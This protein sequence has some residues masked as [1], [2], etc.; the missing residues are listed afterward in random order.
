MDIK[1]ELINQHMNFSD[2]TSQL[3][4]DFFKITYLYLSSL[5]GKMF[6]HRSST[7]SK[8]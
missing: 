7:F 2:C 6:Q 5:F 1:D 8:A 3:I 4:W